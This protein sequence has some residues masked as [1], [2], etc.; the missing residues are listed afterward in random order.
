MDDEQTATSNL[1]RERDALEVA[2][3]HAQ[4]ETRAVS[5][6]LAQAEAALA[7]AEHRLREQDVSVR[8]LRSLLSSTS[9]KVTAPLR[10]LS[11]L[12]RMARRRG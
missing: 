7:H 4:A 11:S 6:K 9:W 12:A 5:R 3:A 1:R 2:L 10:G 8:H